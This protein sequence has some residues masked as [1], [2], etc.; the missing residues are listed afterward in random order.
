VDHACGLVHAHGH[1][2][3]D[4]CG[5]KPIAEGDPLLLIYAS[6]NRDEAVFGPDAGSLQVRRHPNPT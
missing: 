4:G 1:P 6:A 5:A 3:R 2:A